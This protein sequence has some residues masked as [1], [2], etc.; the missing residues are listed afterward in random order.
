MKNK[1]SLAMVDVI[2]WFGVGVFV[3]FILAVINQNLF[4]KGSAQ[5]SD[6]LSGSENYDG[7]EC[8][9][10]FDKCDCEA[11]YEKNE[12]CPV[13]MPTS[14]DVAKKREEVCHNKIKG[15]TK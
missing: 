5:A 8:G 12:C 6:F 9:D 14:G 3:F 10:Y 15:I 2:V 13:G 11:G 1:K 4:G 7:D